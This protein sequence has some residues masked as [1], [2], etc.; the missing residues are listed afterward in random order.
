[1]PAAHEAAPGLL[2]ST[3]YTTAKAQRKNIPPPASSGCPG[4]DET[5]LGGGF[6]YGEITSITGT[7]GTGKTTVG[8]MKHELRRID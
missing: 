3:L 6:R 5:A 1:M 2:G 8:D 7:G 4:I